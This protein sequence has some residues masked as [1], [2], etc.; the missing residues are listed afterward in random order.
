M[1]FTSKAVIHHQ[2]EIAA[3]CWNKMQQISKKCY[4]HGESSVDKHPNI[5]MDEYVSGFKNFAVIRCKYFCIYYLLLKAKGNIRVKLELND[6]GD[7]KGK[8]I[9]D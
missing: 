4:L 9:S 2:D 1:R 5:V 6:N 8:F 3:S 7:I